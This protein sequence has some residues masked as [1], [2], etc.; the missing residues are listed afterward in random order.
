MS[1]AY[2]RTEIAI[3]NLSSSPEISLRCFQLSSGKFC[4]AL[5]LSSGKSVNNG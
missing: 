2:Q 4:C 3:Y 5:V 1:C